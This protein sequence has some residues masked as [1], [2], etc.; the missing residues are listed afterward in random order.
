MQRM[1]IELAIVSMELLADL[2]VNRRR[3]CE[4]SRMRMH[5]RAF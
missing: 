4:F 2:A 3:A 1:R 5:W